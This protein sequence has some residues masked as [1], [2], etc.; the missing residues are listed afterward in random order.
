MSQLRAMLKPWAILLWGALCAGWLPVAHAADT[1]APTRFSQALA[2]A[3]RTAAGLDRL[4]S[5]QIAVIDALIRRDLAA[6]SAPRRAD[7]PPVPGRFTER[8]TADERRTAGLGVLTEE[9]KLKLDGLADRHA[10]S[11]LGRTLLAP[12]AFVPLSIRARVAEA[13]ATGPEIHGSFTLGMGFGKGYSERFGGMT[14]TYEDPVRNFAVSF[15]Y[16]ESHIK[17]AA[18]YYLRDPLNDIDRFPRYS[19]EP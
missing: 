17:G 16:T 14:L 18:P 2:T 15:S 12:P 1:P 11:L 13:K 10:A 3:D 7:A 19:P 9:E 4:S 6:Q 8:L 5:D